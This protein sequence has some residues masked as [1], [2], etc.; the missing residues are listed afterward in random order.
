MPRKPPRPT[1]FQIFNNW[2]KTNRSRFAFQPYVTGGK[3]L[4]SA[5]QIRE[6]EFHFEGI[7]DGVT[8]LFSN[9]GIDIFY[10]EDECELDRIWAFHLSED[11]RWR[12]DDGSRERFWID[13]CFEPFLHWCNTTLFYSSHIE[14]FEMKPSGLKAAQLSG[15]VSEDREWKPL[16]ERYDSHLVMLKQHNHPA[17]YTDYFIPIRK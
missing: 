7:I 6:I 11:R 9:W 10:F 8:C 5:R 14:L 3:V 15:R 17:E 2:L 16:R 1:R 13:G 12:L 4:S